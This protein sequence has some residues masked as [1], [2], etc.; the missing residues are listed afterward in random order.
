M[1]P[2]PVAPV[3][4]EQADGEHKRTNGGCVDGRQ[5]RHGVVENRLQ[6]RLNLQTLG[7]LLLLAGGNDQGQATWK[8]W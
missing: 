3:G 2:P 4:G 7:Q 1:F 5:A 8:G 6:P